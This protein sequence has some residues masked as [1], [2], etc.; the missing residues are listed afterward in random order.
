MIRRA[1]LFLLCGAAAWA[2]DIDGEWKLVYTTGNGLQRE[3]ILEV[4]TE[5]G[6]L[7]GK[8]SSDRGTALI[9]SGAVNR[10]EISFSLLR[11][12]NGDEIKVEF[13]GKIEDGVLK[14][15]MQ[16]GKREPI[17]V[18]GRRI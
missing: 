13:T 15:N 2:A 6:K 7:G 11:K 8:V 14:L 4:K 5:D 1:L 16:F 9:E 10:D 12:G 18:V 3:A 17:A